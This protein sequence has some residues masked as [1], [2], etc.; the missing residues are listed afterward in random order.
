M[1]A[2]ML[3]GFHALSHLLLKQP[4]NY[5]HLRDDVAKA[6]ELRWWEFPVLREAL[7]HFCLLTEAP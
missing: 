6:Q 4:Y 2:T 1:P 7:T 3:D 5:P